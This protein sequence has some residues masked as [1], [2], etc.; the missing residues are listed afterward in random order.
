VLGLG[1]I[2]CNKEYQKVAKSNDMDYKFEKAKDFYNNGDCFKAIPIF[3]ELITYYKGSKDL[4]DLYYS[5]AYCHFIQKEYIVAAYHFQRFAQLY[6]RSP[7]VE[8]AAFMVAKCNHEQSPK[9]NLDQTPTLKAIAEYQR[10][11]ERFPNSPKIPEANAAIDE[12]RIKLHRKAFD[13]AMLYYKLK[14]YQ[15][16]ATSFKSLIEDYPESKDAE[17]AY[18]Y[19]VMS[20]KLFADNSY[21]SKKLERYEATVEAYQKF[22][23]KFPESG[24]LQDLDNVYQK[25]LESMNN[26]PVTPQ[27]KAKYERGS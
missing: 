18:F 15:A 17:R 7:K 21:A 19:I 20:N 4:E 23:V 11:T 8:E 14:D 16:A 5:Y 13:N 22:K 10:F 1:L 26:I 27:N 3:E 2:S 9:F 6:P 12:L 25:V 24:Y